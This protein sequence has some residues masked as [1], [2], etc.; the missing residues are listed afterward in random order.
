MRWIFSLSLIPIL[1]M[2]AC[3][4][5]E[6]CGE[7]TFTGEVQDTASANGVDMNLSFDFEPETCHS[8]CTCDLV[9]YVQMV[10]TVDWE[11]FTYIYPSTEKED[12]ATASGWYIDRLA[13]KIWGY[14][15]RNND[16][17]FA[18]TLDPGSETDPAVL[19]D[20]PS[21][22]EAE[23][24]LEIWWQAVSV[25]VCIDKGSGC[26]NDLLGYYFWSWLVDDAGTVPGIIR[27]L[28]WKNLDDAFDD[29]VLE[30]NAQAPGLGKN[31]FPAFTRLTR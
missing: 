10:R 16:G 9:C 7:F 2:T 31:P 26:L 25:P 1:M 11:D 8:V 28:A 19:F 23:P 30:W 13:G 18:G 4:P 29:A 12:R 3:R 15:G 24:W 5:I 14:Y 27:G 21:R 6:P 20:A 22:G 17:S